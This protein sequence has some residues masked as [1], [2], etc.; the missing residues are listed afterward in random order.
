MKDLIIIGA[1]SAG[2]TASIYA[3]C[4]QIEHMV[5][6]ENLG[7]QLSV[8]TNIINYPGFDLISGEELTERMIS[9][10]KKLGGTIVEGSVSQVK[11]IDNGFELLLV[12]GVKY[13]ARTLIIATGKERRKLQVIGEEEY[14]GKGIL[15]SSTCDES[16]YKDKI[17]A[18]IG[19][20]N[21]AVMDTIKLSALASKVYLLYR[22]K[23]LR[24][25]PVYLD[26][27]KNNPKIEMIKECE[28]AEIM[29]D[30]KSVTGLNIQR[31]GKSEVLSLDRVFIDVGSVPGVA[32][33]MALGVELNEEGFVKV[34]DKLETNIE[35]VFAAGD[36]TDCSFSLEQIVTAAALGA[37]A[38]VS[39]YSYL[40]KGKAPII[41]G[42]EVKMKITT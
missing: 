35:G 3:S 32:L 25:Y 8:A 17:V 11:K 41:W 28:V 2:L 9:Q 23:V 15:F 13:Q 4:F 34:S 21:S 5:I 40:G 27:L 42:S 24:C 33:A 29:G 14:T 26:Q 22:G 36:I 39:V 38:M 6:A 31:E 37:R 1:G 12:S 20:A 16:E 7:G 30:G 10:T 19:G 18:V